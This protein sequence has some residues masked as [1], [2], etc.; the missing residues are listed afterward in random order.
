MARSSRRIRPE[1]LLPRDI[2]ILR[3]IGLYRIG[4]YPV[5][6]RLFCEGKSPAGVLGRLAKPQDK[7]LL[8]PLLRVHRK[9]IGVTKT[10]KKYSYAT[11]LDAALPL[12]SVP[13]TR[14]ESIGPAAI[15]F[16]IGMSWYC[17]CGESR[18]YRLEPEEVEGLWNTD[19]GSLPRTQFFAASEELGHPMLLRLYHATS[20][21][22]T[23]VKR[24]RHHVRDAVDDRTIRPWLEAGDLGFGVMV[25]QPAEVDAYRAAISAERL[26]LDARFVVDVGPTS[27][28]LH[29][30]AEEGD[31]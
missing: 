5:I 17:C 13:G 22:A 28:T 25:S 12:I 15:E 18:R 16:A 31:L 21:A 3:H 24:L 30:V 26:E 7:K 10:R 2:A 14:A 1:D 4:L 27:Q 19:A 11:L 6:S 9:A 23:A 29:L 20:D 8:P